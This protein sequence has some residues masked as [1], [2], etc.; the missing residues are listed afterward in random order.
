MDTS[1]KLT[2][3]VKV[4][5]RSRK[6]EITRLGA[7]E[8]RIRVTSPPSRGEANKAVCKLIAAH[9][10]IPLS[11]VKIIS[12]HKSRNKVVSIEPN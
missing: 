1:K 6:Q 4:Q 9:W 7:N 2:L 12:G 11:R 10:N 8:Y 5:P 3:N